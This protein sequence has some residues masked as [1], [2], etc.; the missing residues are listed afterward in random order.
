M[1]QLIL[2]QFLIVIFIVAQ[3][4]LILAQNPIIKDIYTADPSARVFNG[5]IYLYPSHDRDFA[6]WWDMED[7]H[8][9]SSKNLK[10]WKDHGVALSLKDISWAEKNAWAPD[11]NYKNGK[12]YFYYPTDQNFIGVAIGDKPEGP[13]KD[14]LGS[15]LVDRNTPGVVN[16]RD[17]IDPCI[18]IDDDGTPYL[19]FG[20]NTVNVAILN[21]DMISLKEDVK[22]IKGADHF[23]EAAWLHKYNNKY[24]LSYSGKGKI[25]YAM[26]DNPLGPYEYKG[27]I[28]DKVNSGTNHHSIVQYKGKWYIFYHN[29]DL[30][31]RNIPEGHPDRKYIQ[32][33]RSVCVD[34]LKYYPDGTIKKVKQTKEEVL[35]LK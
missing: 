21:T 12:Y 9:F 8:V 22:I 33:R 15:P 2:K 26:A 13:F 3:G 14:A 7:W 16:N 31:I 32:W 17:L 18:F 1:G 25:L 23:F 29:S 5:K 11:C 35:N 19:Y 27:E 20:Q 28:L 6:Q 4:T 30:A 34:F 10:K 24:Y